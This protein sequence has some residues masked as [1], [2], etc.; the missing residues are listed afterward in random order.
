M[1]GISCSQKYLS[2]NNEPSVKNYNQGSLQLNCAD[3]IKT[4]SFVE[5]NVEVA[6]PTFATVMLQQAENLPQSYVQQPV[7]TRT[8]YRNI[9]IAPKKRIHYNFARSEEESN[10]A[11]SSS[12]TLS[13]SSSER[14]NVLVLKSDNKPTN[15]ANASN[16]ICFSA[17][18]AAAR[19]FTPLMPT[20]PVVHYL[21][22]NTAV[23]KRR[24]SS[25]DVNHSVYTMLERCGSGLASDSCRGKTANVKSREHNV[26]IGGGVAKS[27]KFIRM[28]SA[29]SDGNSDSVTV[30][31]Q[32][33]FVANVS[34][35]NIFSKIFFL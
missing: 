30:T 31:K 33:C 18:N 17:S 24:K 21:S 19:E 12:N 11:M 13:D 35:F 10:M 6:G 1:K 32:S 7:Q 16:E 15:L 20:G 27:Q 4:T 8:H 22:N 14:P 29:D 28:N 34:I 3:S 23:D 26:D 25:G 5:T 9:P 2:G